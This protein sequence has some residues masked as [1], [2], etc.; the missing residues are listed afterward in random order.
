MILRKTILILLS[1]I[2][3]TA[4]G[5]LSDKKTESETGSETSTSTSEKSIKSAPGTLGAVSETK[6][7]DTDYEKKVEK[8]N[9]ITK[10]YNSTSTSAFKSYENYITVFGDD[11]SKFTKTEARDKF[12]MNSSYAL[13]GLDEAMEI[14]VMEDLNPYMENY[15]NSGQILVKTMNEVNM[16]Y[17]MSD[18]DTDGFEKGQ[19]MHKSV[20]EDFQQFYKADSILRIHSGKALGAIDAEYLE[21]LKRDGLTLQY[22]TKKAV[23]D[24]TKIVA[25][26]AETNYEDLDMDKLKA[27]HAPL[28]AT[29]NELT[30]L[31]TNEPETY[32]AQL[33]ISFF[34][35]SLESLVLASTALQKRIK[36]KRPFSM[37]EKRNLTGSAFIA[38]T[39]KGSPQQ[40]NERYSDMID[41]YNSLN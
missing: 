6:P 30:A 23:D 24:A 31:K 19:T 10:N 36:D 14:P 7:D 33:G 4:C 3:L 11:P 22:L 40:V 32:N 37:L 16:Y 18:Y 2:A 35:S 39:V 5:E 25:M 38:S 13:N 29:F 41:H 28:R 1:A 8:I 27:L 9:A 15:K 17:R 34:Y 26:L 12:A 21:I 20:I